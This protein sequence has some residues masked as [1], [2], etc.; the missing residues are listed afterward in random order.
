M[1]VARLLFPAL[2]WDE[3]TGFEG[4]AESIERAL[5][6]GVGGFIVF[7]GE[8]DAVR[9]VI[10]G[11]R[12][13]SA[14]PLLFGADLERGAGQ[15]FRGATPLPPL[16]ALGSLDDLASTR[17]AGELTAREARA[18]GVDWVYAPVADLD[19]EPRN[20][21]VGTRSFGVDP[22][23]VGAQLEAWIEGCRAGGALS[24]AKHF[25]GHGRTTSDSHLALPVVTAGRDEL[26]VDLAPFRRAIEARVDS[27]MT[28]HVAYPALDPSGAP[29]T[30]SPRIITGLLR[31]ELG[32]DG[33]VVTD[34]LIMEG[35]R[36]EEGGEVSAAVRALMAGCDLL[37]YPDD[38]AAVARELEAALGR[39]LSEER[40]A[41]SLE[42]LERAA[43]RV[44]GWRGGGGSGAGEGWGTGGAPGPEGVRGG[45]RG[46]G[47][48]ERADLGRN[49]GAD[50]DRCWALDLAL[51]TIQIARGEP[52]H[53][54]GRAVELFTVDDD[55][56][57]PFPPPSRD[58][59]PASLRAAGVEVREVE[60][61]ASQADAAGAGLAESGADA[62]PVIALYADIRGWK[63]RPGLSARAVEAL[64]RIQATR[65]GAL[66]VL[67]GHPRLAAEIPGEGAV[68]AAWGGEALA[69]EAAGVWLAGG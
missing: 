9:E 54:A 13:R 11:I 15:Q 65:P 25:P 8:A 18:L 64:K 60:A 19:L 49:W 56:G 55:I 29:A 53:L 31:E 52:A 32:F 48:G 59:F 5:E 4:A 63:G 7:G 47:A 45:G 42:R 10:A 17:R 38:P 67:F 6:L 27:I 33:L 61:G 69:Q 12:R 44:A 46:W 20:P 16:A 39:T 2:R 21:I 35:V 57:G 23:R 41:K 43:R 28:A 1:K 68:V 50:A 14:E 37:L 36:G 3:R 34:A 30:L 26:E 62:V 22:E 51:R 58:I 24:C 40:V 66:V